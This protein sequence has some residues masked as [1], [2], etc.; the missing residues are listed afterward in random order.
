M[1]TVVN[2]FRL[3]LGRLLEKYRT[4]SGQRVSEVE[5]HSKLRWSE[6]KFSKIKAGVRVPSASETH[7]LADI[8]GLSDAE[9]DELVQLADMA[10]K[11]VRSPVTADFAKTSVLFEQ[12]A[13]GIDHYGEE[14]LPAILQEEGYARRLREST[15]AHNVDAWVDD[16]M[17]RAAILDKPN[18]PRVRLV[19]SESALYRVPETCAAAQLQR[20]RHPSVQLRILPFGLGLHRAIGARFTTY[21]LASGLRCT[22]LEGLTE[23]TYFHD[24]DYYVGV[25]NDIWSLT[26]AAQSET[27]LRRRILETERREYGDHVGS[28]PSE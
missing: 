7:H 22:Y 28:R 21:E 12:G 4:A 20:L 1:T 26:T 24:D 5:Q 16:R 23:A 3:E 17:R 8:F 2:P 14:L 6:G 25:F 27:I 13:T 10:R 11:K 18:A 15:G 9:R 19:L